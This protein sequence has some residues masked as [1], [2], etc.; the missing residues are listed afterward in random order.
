MSYNFIHNNID[1][2]L[3]G[4]VNLERLNLSFNGFHGPLPTNPGNSMAL[5][6]FVLYVN[7]FDE[8][9][10]EENLRYKNLSLLDL[11]F[12]KLSGW[13]LSKLNTFIQDRADV[14]LTPIERFKLR[15]GNNKLTRKIKLKK[16]SRSW[17]NWTIQ[18]PQLPWAIYDGWGLFLLFKFVDIL[19]AFDAV[20]SLFYFLIDFLIMMI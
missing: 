4:L 7:H 13:N 16:N 17:Q 14:S 3:A 9:I 6:Q 12:N 5:E 2:Q 15:L 8:T 19:D 1:S 18:M 20:V 10:P 11:G